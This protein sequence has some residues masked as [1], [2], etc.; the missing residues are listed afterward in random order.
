MFAVVVVVA[1]WALY[2]E[3]E[4]EC[5]VAAAGHMPPQLDAAFQFVPVAALFHV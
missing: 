3:A 4:E 5:D 2:E 1:G